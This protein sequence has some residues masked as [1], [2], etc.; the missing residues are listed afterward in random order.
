[1]R[2]FISTFCSPAGFSC[3][4]P[5]EEAGRNQISCS[6]YPAKHLLLGPCANCGTP[7]LLSQA[8]AYTVFSTYKPCGSPPVDPHQSSSIGH[9]LP[10]SPAG[11]Q[12]PFTHLTYKMKRLSALAS[13]GACFSFSTA[14]PARTSRAPSAIQ[15]IPIAP[16]C[17]NAHITQNWI[18]ADCPTGPD[19]DDTIE[20][21]VYLPNKITNDD[22]VLKW[23]AE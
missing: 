22:G 7:K 2:C 4:L 20:S 16:H 11:R 13:L 14:A 12:A 5:Q 3:Q 1:M 17:T 23:K 10:L 21:A 8:S 18:V 9:R 19:S 6:S 15:P